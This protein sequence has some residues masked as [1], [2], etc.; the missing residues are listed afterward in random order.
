M[1]TRSAGDWTGSPAGG[2]LN[3]ALPTSTYRLGV[4][5]VINL[6]ARAA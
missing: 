4:T 1:L 2:E 5:Q 3:C 6:L